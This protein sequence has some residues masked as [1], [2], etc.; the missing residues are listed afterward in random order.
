MQ[1]RVPEFADTSFIF[2]EKTGLTAEVDSV[3]SANQVEPL[4]L[5]DDRNLRSIVKGTFDLCLPANS[6][7]S[8]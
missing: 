8:D 7:D 4:V 2:V 3:Q 1:P 6:F 5:L